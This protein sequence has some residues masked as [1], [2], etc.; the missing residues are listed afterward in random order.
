[1]LV[2]VDGAMTG[3][4]P[5]GGVAPP[6]TVTLVALPL[7]TTNSVRQLVP[8]APFALTAIGTKSRTRSV[9]CASTYRYPP[10]TV[11]DGAGGM[12]TSRSTTPAACGGAMT[13]IS[14]AVLSTHV[15]PAPP[16]FTYAKQFAKPHRT[17]SGNKLFPCTCTKPPPAVE[18]LAG[19]TVD[20][21]GCDPA[22]A[23]HNNKHT[24]NTF[25]MPYL[26]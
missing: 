21:F 1:M 17:A 26:R 11:N 6:D 10:G 2:V 7:C 18:P 8:S 9:G 13:T 12:F 23:G 4:V 16:D 14:F 24:A 3:A 22:N 20:T 15:P 5:L 25:L 19:V